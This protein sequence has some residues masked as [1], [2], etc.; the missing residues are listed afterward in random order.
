MT[1]FQSS[2][3]K[4]KKKQESV[5]AKPTI[6]VVPEYNLEIVAGSSSNSFDTA[7]VTFVEKDGT[8]IKL[9]PYQIR[10]TLENACLVPEDIIPVVIRVV[11]AFKTL[12]RV[13]K[14]FLCYKYLTEIIKNICVSKNT[15][16]HRVQLELPGL[17]VPEFKKL[18][19]HDA[20]AK[21]RQLLIDLSSIALYFS[22]RFEATSSTS[23]VF[24]V[25][26]EAVVKD[27]KDLLDECKKAR[28]RLGLPSAEYDLLEASK[29][30][31]ESH[32][33]SPATRSESENSSNSVL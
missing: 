23:S 14:P 7:S 33:V 6:D 16:W 25:N 20:E 10:T 5:A 15:E 32:G 18:T 13:I 26:A 17:K 19:G 21:A 2:T 28:K 31:H 30:V 9:T 12:F 11:N 4:R 22:V 29:K 27:A 24:S 1:C 8:K 3:D